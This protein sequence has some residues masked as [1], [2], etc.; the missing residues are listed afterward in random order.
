MT[1]F[2]V[3]GPVE[4]CAGG[5]PLA[6]GG[7]RQLKLLAFLVLHA[8]RAVSRDALIEAVWGPDREG[9]VKR[10]QMAIARLRKALE[11]VGVEE[12][13][14]L[15]T[16]SGGYLLQV[17]PGELDAEVFAERVRDGRGALEEGDPARASEALGQAL[18]LWRGPPLAEV[19]FEDFAQAEIRRL[20][21]LRLSALEMRIDAEL[22]LGRHGE[23]IDELESQFAQ[24]PTREVLAGQLMTALYR[25]GRQ[26][27]ALE[28]YQRARGRLAEELGLEPGPALKTL[29]TQILDQA[30][31]LGFASGGARSERPGRHPAVVPS[32]AQ[33]PPR[34]IRLIGRETELDEVGR[35][36]VDSA[37]PLVTLTGPGGTGK[38]TLALE[39]A[40]R[41]DGGFADGVAV[42]WLAS[43]TEAGQLVT[44]LA[45]VL[46]IEL[47]ATEA[48]VETII[49][50]LRGQRRLIVLDN[51][52]HV[53][54][55]APTVAQL[56]AWCP[57]VTVL[58]TSRVPL[59][60]GLER[61]YLVPGLSVPREADSAAALRRYPASAL[62]LERATARD[63][64]F[65]VGDE[66][67]AAVAELCRYL[68]G[69]P[70]ALEL[71]AARCH[72]LS[73]DALLGV[74]RRDP[75]EGLAD[76][77]RD[78]PP[79]QRTLRSTIEWSYNL[80]SLTEKMIFA[81]LAVF[82]GSFALDG[83]VA[84]CGRTLAESS[85]LDGIGALIDSSLVSRARTE[86]G[87]PRFEMMDTIRGFARQQLDRA[88]DAAETDR[89]HATHYAGLADQAELGLQG[90]GQATWLARLDAEQAN[91]RAALDWSLSSGEC[92]P[93]LQ[94][95]GAL[96][97]Y[98][99]VRDQIREILNWIERALSRHC[100]SDAARAKAM[101]TGGTLAGQFMQAVEA[102]RLLESSVQ[103]AEK[104]NDQEFLARC[105]SEL[106]WAET[107]VGRDAQARRLYN[108]AHT[109]ALETRSDLLLAEVLKVAA[110]TGVCGSEELESVQDNCLRLFRSLGD[111]LSEV[112]VL[113]N[114]G[115]SGYLA[116]LSDDLPRARDLLDQALALSDRVWSA[117]N[118][119]TIMGNMGLVEL[120][121]GNLAS[122]L[123][124]FRDS[125]AL[126]R[127]AGDPPLI[128]ENM[129]GIAAITASTGQH[130]L[131]IRL[132]TA[133]TT[134]A[135]G[136]P[137]EAE[138]LILERFVDPLRGRLER[139]QWEAAERD[140]HEMGF[141]A[142]VE[143]VIEH[144]LTCP[145]PQ[146]S[147]RVAVS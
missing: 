58:V 18:A 87:E 14:V 91:L 98:W 109:V 32:V 92:E 62:F 76:G 57:Q 85:V 139:Q 116:L 128:R 34:A 35:L 75:L 41:A 97:R 78:A 86:A 104:L 3:L 30:P 63:A 144:G 16:V 56:V 38:T 100:G 68:G 141:D 72:V 114:S 74:L 37:V 108:R 146:P 50:A 131:A 9:A 102:K 25:S 69:L 2:R 36:L 147:L 7:A 40:R 17:A 99:Q 12:A 11:P 43:I 67:A 118:R 77:M 66:H 84:V 112:D 135:P 140:G 59:R 47:S 61:V 89:R 48:P 65:Q 51:F 93:G 111:R 15:R 129:L 90:P 134:G 49:R 21:E 13:S 119:A 125:M 60:V 64:T 94:I 42:A 45:R 81:R 10:L 27:D 143:A 1:S 133:A 115:N 71:A 39:A 33:L 44:E 122:A 105:L 53:L 79:R 145:G 121:A 130:V 113:N 136:E 19:F 96:R 137:G 95:A 55:A 103:L 117:S 110:S 29:Q 88:D 82:R 120:F 142:A 5:G 124:L 26:A 126:A 70:L 54:S 127:N 4:V 23:L 28:V 101:L 138:Q 8:N 83:A 22:R 20:E 107:R 123:D 6:V 106:A 80:L 46:G 52:E 132:A 24:H 73:P 31:S